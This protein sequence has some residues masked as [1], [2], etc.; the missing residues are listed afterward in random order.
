MISVKLIYF[1]VNPHDGASAGAG[2]PDTMS[3]FLILS[4]VCLL[5]CSDLFKL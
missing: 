3:S 1:F 4:L 5:A 2:L